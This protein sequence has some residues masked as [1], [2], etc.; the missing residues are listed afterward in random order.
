MN[1]H[2]AHNRLAWI[3]IVLAWAAHF[4]G[5]FALAMRVK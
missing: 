1:R 5:V 3:A 2:R 4:S